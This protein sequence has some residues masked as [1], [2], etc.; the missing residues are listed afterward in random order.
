M[1]IFNFIK[2]VIKIVLIILALMFAYVIFQVA[3]SDEISKKVEDRIGEN[4]NKKIEKL[5]K[6]LKETKEIQE[7]S[8]KTLKDMG[9]IN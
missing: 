6:D 1:K 4:P 5:N 3:T 9:Y 8:I 2:K 7:S